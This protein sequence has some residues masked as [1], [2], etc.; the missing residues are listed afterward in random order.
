M[1]S[2]QVGTRR[3]F[4]WDRG[5]SVVVFVPSSVM[6]VPGRL[7]AARLHAGRVLVEWT[8]CR[9]RGR[10]PGHSPRA[11]T[12]RPGPRRPPPRPLAPSCLG[13]GWQSGLRLRPHGIQRQ[14]PATLAAVW[15]GALQEVWKLELI[16]VLAIPILGAR[17]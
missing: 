17:L 16:P 8:G 14:E 7:L 13:L 6:G 3:V 1:T 2:W 9:A 11:A 4:W 15:G 5:S 12:S 10:S